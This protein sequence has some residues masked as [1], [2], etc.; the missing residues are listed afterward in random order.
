MKCHFV[1]ARA[2]FFAIL[3]EKL[4]SEFA[5]IPSSL[6]D[7]EHLTACDVIIFGLPAQEHPEY[8]TRLAQLQ[9][10]VRNPAGVPVIA[11]LPTSDRQM[12]RTAMMAGSMDHFVESGSMEELRHILRRASQFH[13]M[14]RELQRLRFSG[15]ELG[16]FMSIVGSDQK[17]R[18]IFTLASKVAS[19]DATVLITGETGTGK[20][21]LA[22]AIHQASQRARQ[23]FVAV[24]CSSLPETLIEAE[25]F[26]HEKGAFTGAA[27]ARRGRFEAAE[28]GTI[29]LDEIGELSPGLQVKLLRVLQERSFE[30][31]GSNQPRPMEARVICATNRTLQE[32][33]RAATFRA[34]LYYRLNTIELNL[35][36]L[37]ERRDDIALL[38][39]SF[40]QGYSEKHKRPG[41]RICSAAMAALQEYS[42]PGNIRELQNVI[43]RAVVI[44]D[45]PEILMEHL[46]SQFAAWEDQNCIGCSFE[47]EVRNF[48]RRLIQRV[49]CD[50]GNNKL[51]AARTLGIARSSLHR[52]IDELHIPVPERQNS[53]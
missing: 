10:I 41:R 34:D 26:G 43:E 19:T 3:A 38:A 2:E 52:L 4:G 7:R 47:D 15:R 12:V 5:L 18:A 42:W 25:L 11:F 33:V 9:K 49:L 37:R 6:E 13:D 20:E 24:A 32:L 17:M 53:D 21:L 39:H 30:R 22:R 46:P 45:G 1:D 31:L 48:K 27:A 36:P 44:C 16:D 28:R 14:N 8:Q 50:H 23:P 35:P 40:L 51:Q 29:F